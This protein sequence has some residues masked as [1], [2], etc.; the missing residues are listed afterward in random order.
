MKLA[1]VTLAYW[2]FFSVLFQLIFYVWDCNTNVPTAW[3]H[4][5]HHFALRSSLFGSQVV[6][7]TVVQS[8]FLRRF[9]YESP[10][11]CRYRLES[12]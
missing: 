1:R 8:V 9:Y 7:V 3:C 6:M 4:Y 2:D 11:S 10:V 5:H 12:A